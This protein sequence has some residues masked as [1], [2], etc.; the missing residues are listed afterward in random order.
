MADLARR[1]AEGWLCLAAWGRRWRYRRFYWATWPSRWSGHLTLG[2]GVR[3]CAPLRC[4]GEGVVSVADRTTL[5]WPAAGRYGNGSVMLQARAR[6]AVIKIG[7]NCMFSNNVSV[8]A[9]DSVEIADDCL[10]GELVS[11]MDSDFHGV[12][13]DQRRG[14]PVKTAPVRLER[15]VWLGSRVIVQKGV[16]IGANSIVT[17]NAVVTSSVP[18]DCI[19]GGVPARVIRA[20][21]SPG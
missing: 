6:G 10:I 7:R 20:L 17:P 13:P 1:L 3:L 2:E 4:D 11:I 14:G 21:D 18:A 19:A 5:G 8:F 15:N 16:T 12:A 9:V